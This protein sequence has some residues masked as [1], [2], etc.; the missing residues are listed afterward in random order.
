VSCG[1]HVSF[2][3]PTCAACALERG[4]EEGRR[5]AYIEMQ[6]GHAAQ[7]QQCA[8]K[9][10]H[11]DWLVIYY[12]EDGTYHCLECVAEEYW[13]LQALLKKAVTA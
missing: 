12:P 13:R 7:K 5:E 2:D 11:P 10:S 9:C 6:A 8:E 4:R 1:H 3:I